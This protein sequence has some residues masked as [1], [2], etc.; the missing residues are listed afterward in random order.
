[1]DWIYQYWLEVLFGSAVAGLS[2]AYRKLSKKLKEQDSV[3]NGVKALLR[4]R[5]VQAY[6]HCLEKGYCPIY[7]QE[8]AE[9]LY[10]EYHELG[11]NGTV[12][13]LMEDLR[14]LPKQPKGGI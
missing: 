2:Y 10:K 3:K 14:Q 4:D 11:G 1:M 6:N 5:I 12:T 7:A 9:A 8:N 13:T